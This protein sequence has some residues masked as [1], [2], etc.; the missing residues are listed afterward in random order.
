MTSDNMKND[1][2]NAY[3]GEKTGLET[4]NAT[5]GKVMIKV[6]GLKKYY[7]Y[8]VVKALD[9]IDI[10]INKGDCMVVIGPSGSGNRRS[11]GALTSSRSRP[12]EALSSMTRISRMRR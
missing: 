12:M 8:G 6:Q 11:S 2:A 4:M 7:K 5:S 3:I 10:E 9:G 1:T